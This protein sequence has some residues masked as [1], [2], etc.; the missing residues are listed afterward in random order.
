[1]LIAVFAAS[2]T[3]MA[4]TAPAS[5]PATQAVVQK[6]DQPKLICHKITP[7]GSRMPT[8][9]CQTPEQIAQERADAK[10]LTRDMQKI[11]P[12]QMH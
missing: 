6:T 9:V 2:L 7:L 10:E 11:N 3:L 12:E 1:M 4:D 8:K 5:T